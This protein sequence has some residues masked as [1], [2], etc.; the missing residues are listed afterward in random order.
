MTQLFMHDRLLLTY[1][2]THQGGIW[3]RGRLDWADGSWY[4]G[5]TTPS[6]V[7]VVSRRTGIAYQ[8]SVVPF[9][10]ACVQVRNVQGVNV[11]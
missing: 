4:E 11:L 10:G 5:P 9:A 2:G 1:R 8:V 7:R 3:Q 6:S